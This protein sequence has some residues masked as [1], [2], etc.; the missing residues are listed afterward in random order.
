MRALPVLVVA[1][2]ALSPAALAETIQ[3][4]PERA[5][6]SVA[7]VLGR[8]KPGDVVEVDP[9]TYREAMKV[10]LDGRADAPIT[11]RGVPGKER[12]VFDARDLDISGQKG[13]TR[14]IF[15]L[16]GAYIVLE[17]LEL[18][19]ARNGETAAGVRLNG[20]TNA[21][22]RDCR[23]H[24]CDLGVFGDDRETVT[25]E[26]CDIGFN[27]T[28]KW[29]GY[30]HNF[31]M[32]GNRVVVRGCHIHDSPFG[33]NFK[34]RAHYNELWYNWIADSDEGEVGPVDEHARVKGG[35]QLADSNVVMVGNVIVS[36]PRRG[37]NGSK[38]VLFGSELKDTAGHNG[39]LFMFNNTLVAGSPE[40]VFVQ[41]ADA[42][43][44]LVAANNIFAGSANILRQTVP[45][46]S[47]TGH[48]NWIEKDAKAP[49]GFTDTLTGESPGF[50][51]AGERDFRLK[52]GSP[53]IGAGAPAAGL[54]YTD[55]DGKAH[56]LALDQQYAPHLKLMAR[57][58]AARPALGA[59]EP[60]EE[61]AK[62][63]PAPPPAEK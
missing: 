58:D 9:G 26:L 49:E 50:V 60:A 37:G 23:I 31:Y 11:I 2:L 44:R 35:T 61:G 16:E 30:A 40:I 29:R 17:H 51:A 19:N 43:A 54:E 12:P 56:K 22:V 52:A 36:K 6:K 28:E 32:H 48:H 57:G 42:K 18:T 24:H 53:C 59:R 62:P 4:G 55:G 21:V 63:E 39:T 41:L 14:A 8:L 33:Q 34:S 25:I 7:A 27:S 10:K 47:V 5:E 46:A 15:Q 45:A 38:F 3:V 20:S 1:V 13:A